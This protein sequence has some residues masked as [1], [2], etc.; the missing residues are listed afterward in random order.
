M[1]FFLIRFRNDFGFELKRNFSFFLT[2]SKPFR[3]I[4]VRFQSVVNDLSFFSIHMRSY[5]S[6]SMF[7]QSVLA[8]V[9]ISY[10]SLTMFFH[11]LSQVN[12]NGTRLQLQPAFFIIKLSRHDL[13]S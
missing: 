11:H 13:P 8:F 3:F 1:F 9:A 2:V 5:C 6:L 10:C 12:E 4:Y 7:F